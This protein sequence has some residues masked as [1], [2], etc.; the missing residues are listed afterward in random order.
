MAKKWIT[1]LV[2][3]VLV[4]QVILFGHRAVILSIEYQKSNPDTIVLN[5]DSTLS[6]KIV[7]EHSEIIDRAIREN[8]QKKIETFEFNPNTVSQEEL[9]RLGFSEK[10]AKSIVN[11][12]SKGGKFKRKQDFAK[13]YAVP[14]DIYKR[15]ESFIVIP[16]IDINKADTLKLQFLPGIGSYYSRK[17]V[18][19]R[20]ELHGYSYI[21]QLLDLWNFDRDKLEDIQDLIICSPNE[22]YPL[23]T[24]PEDSLYNHPY[25]RHSARDIVKFRKKHDKREWTIDNLMEDGIIDEYNGNKLKKCNILAP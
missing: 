16:K 2:L 20:Q 6:H 12:R 21:E 19:H 1:I 5:Y 18:E 25:I 10:Q 11:Y 4:F 7:T 13:S 23:W 9:E 22:P 24:L 17:I 8:R 15:L 3:L 14:E